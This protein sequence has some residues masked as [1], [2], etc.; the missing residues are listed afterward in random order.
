MEFDKNRDMEDSS[1]L[2]SLKISEMAIITCG[3]V[4]LTSSSEHTSPFIAELDAS[5]IIDWISPPN[6]RPRYNKGASSL[7][8]FLLREYPPASRHVSKLVRKVPISEE[9]L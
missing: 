6:L 7:P 1:E 4:R 2:D 9:I 8:K 5:R 3:S